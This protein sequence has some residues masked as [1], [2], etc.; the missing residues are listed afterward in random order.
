MYF[1]FIF[2]GFILHC[3]GVSL[4]FVDC[5]MFSVSLETVLYKRCASGLS[6]EGE[7]SLSLPPSGFTS[8]GGEVSLAGSWGAVQP[9]VSPLAVACCLESTSTCSFHLFPSR[10]P[11]VWF[12]HRAWHKLSPGELCYDL[13]VPLHSMPR[14]FT[15]QCGRE[16]WL[17]C[18]SIVL[19]GMENPSQS[20]PSPIDTDILGEIGYF[21]KF[22][23][24]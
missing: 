22:I 20:C 19:H 23:R 24:T 13:L 9:S 21:Q 17:Y 8:C 7:A 1:P 11:C 3:P 14:G 12:L 18:S 10:F 5:G 16:A 4:L 15:H 2:T 6:K